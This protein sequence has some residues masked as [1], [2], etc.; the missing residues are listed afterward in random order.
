MKLRF[1]LIVSCCVTTLSFLSV[2]HFLKQSKTKKIHDPKY[3]ITAIIQTGPEKEALQTAFLEE[4]L[5]LSC[6]RP[7]NLYAFDLKVAEKKILSSPLISEAHIKKIP[8][9]IVYI[10]YTVRKPIAR[11]GDYQNVAIDKDGYLFPLLPF[12][13]PKELPEI[14]LG[15]PPFGGSEDS[16]G[17]KGGEWLTPLQNPHFQLAIEILQFLEGSP[18]REGIRI[19]RLDVSNAFAKSLGTREIVLTTEEEILVKTHLCIFPKILRLCPK[20]YE[21]QMHHFLVLRKN[22]IED[23]SRQLTDAVIPKS[24]KFSSRIVDLR[25]PHLAF[26]EN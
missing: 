21:K 14:Y 12:Y 9:N 4:L 13:A 20:N 2:Q 25:I 22:M 17:R 3:D 19:K 6:D 26:V 24:G 5:E 15:L 16:L 23:Y 11:L 10:D 8:P 1:V 18:W 7:T